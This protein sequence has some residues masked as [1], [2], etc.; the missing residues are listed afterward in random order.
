MHY[1]DIERFCIFLKKICGIFKI[2][3]QRP[4]FSPGGKSEKLKIR[5]KLKYVIYVEYANVLSDWSDWSY[6]CLITMSTSGVAHDA[7]LEYC[8]RHVQSLLRIEVRPASGNA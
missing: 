6:E 1:M 3:N 4:A 7:S 8:D 5:Q 2:W